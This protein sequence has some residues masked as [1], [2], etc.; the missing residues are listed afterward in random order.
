MV[1]TL[2]IYSALS[3]LL[4]SHQRGDAALMELLVPSPHTVH[5]FPE[6]MC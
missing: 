5:L 3:L 1:Y 6:Y 4:F 2:H